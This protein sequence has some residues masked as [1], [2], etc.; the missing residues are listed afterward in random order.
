MLPPK[1]QEL[2]DGME[3]NRRAVLCLVS[4]PSDAEFARKL[5]G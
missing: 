3:E 4:G 5:R 1:L 2:A